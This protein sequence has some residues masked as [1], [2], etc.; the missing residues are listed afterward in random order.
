MG[1]FNSLMSFASK[2][3]VGAIVLDPTVY[4]ELQKGQE[5]TYR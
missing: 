4:N 3:P 5:N 2:Q 1:I